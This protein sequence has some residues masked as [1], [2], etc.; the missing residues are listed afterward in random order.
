MCKMYV[1]YVM[2]C[3]LNKTGLLNIF[4]IVRFILRCSICMMMFLYWV[5]STEALLVTS[6]ETGLD[7]NA[8]KTKCLFMSY[9]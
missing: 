7:L 1:V 4:S 8:E 2:D 3:L 5:K 6:K 9:K